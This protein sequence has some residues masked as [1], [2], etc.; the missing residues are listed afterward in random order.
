MPIIKFEGKT[1]EEA[2]EKACNQLHIASDQLK[3]EIESTGSAG[4]FGLGSKKASIR[5]IVEEKISSKKPEVK[6]DVE[7]VKTQQAEPVSFYK[8]EPEVKDEKAVREK[9]EDAET[10]D[11]PYHGRPRQSNYHRE[12]EQR[13]ERPTSSLPRKDENNLPLPATVAA[14][15][16]DYY[17]GPEDEI[18]GRARISLEGI[19]DRMGLTAEVGVN[20]IEDRIILKVEGDNSGLL[21][22]KKGATLDAL[23]FLVNKIV[24]KNQTEKYRVI[25]DSENYRERRHQ[26]LVELA[27]R[28]AERARRTRRPVTIS[29]LSAHDRRVVHLA[30]QEKQGLRTRSRGEG[31]L[32]NIIIIPG[33][34]KPGGRHPGG[35]GRRDGRSGKSEFNERRSEPAYYD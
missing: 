3:F 11:Q 18:M 9:R 28:M 25:V 24:N 14:P 8:P 33:N 15:G 7:E 31:P 35:G 16:E 22:G 10:H 34:K 26:T 13:Y 17:Q 21:I 19:L 4:I 27:N 23:Q 20:R 2:I 29:Q 32:K 1:T 12:P 6:S 30:L 5:V